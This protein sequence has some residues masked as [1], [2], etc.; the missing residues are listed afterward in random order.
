MYNKSPPS[1]TETT[2]ELV[3]KLESENLVKSLYYR[4]EGNVSEKQEN[5]QQDAINSNDPVVLLCIADEH[6]CQ[7]IRER[8]WREAR[9]PIQKDSSFRQDE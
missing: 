9:H 5:M 8:E 2:G 7:F 3:I 1:G 6:R 4:D